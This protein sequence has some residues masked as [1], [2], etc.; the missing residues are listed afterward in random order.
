MFSFSSLSVFVYYHHDYYYISRGAEA[1]VEGQACGDP[2]RGVCP[3]LRDIANYIA[4]L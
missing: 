3:A 2:G 1:P 4:N